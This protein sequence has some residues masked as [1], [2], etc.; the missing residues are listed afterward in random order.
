MFE[1][2]N[3]GQKPVV[4]IRTATAQELA[5]YEKWKQEKVKEQK[6]SIRR[7]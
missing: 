2:R 6:K 3:Y 1:I 5:A 4:V 7:K